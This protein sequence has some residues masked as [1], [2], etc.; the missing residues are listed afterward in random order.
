MAH[1]RRRPTARRGRRSLKLL[2]GVLASFSLL[3]GAAHAAP[4]T[5]V[6]SIG[7]DVTEIVYA[8]GEEKRIVGVDDTSVYPASA[9]ALPHVGYL[10]NLSAEGIISLTPDLVLAAKAAGP[11]AVVAQLG[12]AKISLVHVTGADSLDGVFAKIDI[13]AKALGAVARGATL[14]AD[15]AAQMAKV[16]QALAGVKVKPKALFLLAQ[17]PAGAL[18][19][20]RG[21]AADAMITLAHGT[22]VASGFEGYKPLTAESAIALAPEVIIVA[23][24]AVQML[25]GVEAMKARP[26]IA[27]TPAAKNN[28][29]VVMD[30]Q[31]LLGFGPRLPEAVTQLAVALHPGVKLETAAVK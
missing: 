2:F 22:N 29:I 5:R 6:V 10:R 1:D 26:E 11:Q 16:D 9:H 20:G 25:G 30:A 14:K 8:L 7:G 4:G 18:A 23:E 19:A 24:H 15:L 27:I 17:G 13:V 28:R 21:S 31:M 12:D 3:L